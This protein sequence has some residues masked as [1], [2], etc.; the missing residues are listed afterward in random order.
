VSTSASGNT[1]IFE[2][3][4]ALLIALLGLAM[5]AGGGQL[6]LLGGSIY[7]VIA[8]AA[9][10]L[11]AIQI[12]RGR[13]SGYLLYTLVCI[14][15]IAWALAESGLNGWALLPRLNLVLGLGLALMMVRAVR[16]GSDGL[17][18][19]T[20]VV[21]GLLVVGFGGSLWAARGPERTDATAGP[22]AGMA[23]T[24]WLDIGG[25][26]GNQRFSRLNQ[27]TPDN[28]SGLKIAWTAHLAKDG[29]V[30]GVLEATPIKV[31]D[32]LYMCDM[33][34][35]VHAL[36]ADTGKS[37]WIF[38]PPSNGGD[39]RVTL[40]RGVTHARIA[41]MAAGEHCADRIIMPASFAALFAVDARDGT[42]CK[43]FGK[44]GA[45]DVMEGLSP[46]IK[47]YYNLTSPPVYIRGKLVLGGSPLDG[48][49]TG[50]PSGVIRAYDA[51][52]G[53]FAW[54]WDMGRPDDQGMPPKGQYFTP[55]TP[56]AWP[57]LAADEK[58]G[59][60]FLPTGNATPDYVMSH[61]TPAMN[62]YASSTIALDAET[63]KLVWSFQSV[64]L[65]QWDY[66]VASPPTLIDFPMPDGT[67]R[68]AVVQGTKRGQT[69][70]LDRLTG[71]PLVPVT[72]RKVPTDGVPTETFAP[73]QPY[74]GLPSMFGEELSEAK[75]WGMT[76][77]DQLWCRIKFKQARYEGEFT[78]IMS[79]RSSIIYP[80]YIGGSNWQGVGYDP[81]RQL[82][83]VNVN[84]FPMYNR[85]IARK[86]ADRMG[87]APYKP[88]VNELDVVYWAQMG[89][90]WAMENKKFMGPL[91]TPCNEPPFGTLAVI[92]M[93]T[94]KFAWRQPIGKARDIGPFGFATH[95]PYTIGT[96]QLGGVLMT[97]TG[98]MFIGGTQEKT[99]RALDTKTGRVLWEDRLPAGAHAN[100]MTYYSDRS[101]RQFVVVAASGHYQF[102]NGQ[103]DLLIAYALP[104]K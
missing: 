35:R 24:D 20:L 47:G 29:Q 51:R 26:D 58:S 87:I 99:F 45:V 100:P 52:T 97:G 89:T 84:H 90:P 74:S 36:D 18:K 55:G 78:P 40:C 96:P 93:R 48:Q 61:R 59:L 23:S 64:Y 38:T 21:V 3:I 44:D 17:R 7:Y 4:V 46:A 6:A 13:G 57:P 50:E 37:R 53:A 77:L 54:A 95:L 92:D 82:L 86:D 41:D 25:G 62:K 80:S 91:G 101:G 70:V 15:T 71:K 76:P 11:S 34:N 94:G 104:R 43:D 73:T 42:A 8:G 32:T 88:G 67:T 102:A 9:M 27:I 49:G 12:W 1:G 85:L 66:D 79:D 103:S 72:E 75:M 39:S 63:G 33:A 68:P 28:V 98:L 5:A 69:F 60:V 14:G 2:R 81:V 56:N 22:L 31:G 10:V 19:A 83:A 16:G 65:D 30:G